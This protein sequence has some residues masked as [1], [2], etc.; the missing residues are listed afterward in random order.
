MASSTGVL[1]YPVSYAR[2]VNPDIKPALHEAAAS[3][4][5]LAWGSVFDKL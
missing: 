4:L 3:I 5:A 2:A 1:K